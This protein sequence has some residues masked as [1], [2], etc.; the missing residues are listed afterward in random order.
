MTVPCKDSTHSIR[1]FT[2][3]PVHP[4]RSQRHIMSIPDSTPSLKIAVIAST[5]PRHEADYAVP[6]LRESIRHLVRRGHEVTVLAPSYEGLSDHAIDGVAVK[7]FRYSPRRWER[8]THEQGAPNR[9]R[10]PWYQLLGAPYVILGCLAA[11]RLAAKESFDIVHVHWPFPHAPLGAAATS[12][13]GAPLVMT[14]HGAEFALARRKPWVRECLKRGLRRADILIANS[15]DTAVQIKELSG[16]DAEVLAFGSTVEPKSEFHIPNEVPRILFTGRLIQ[17]KGV[18][19]LLR[20]APRVLERMRAKFII[21]GDGDQRAA[22]ERLR[23]ELS[24]Q[25]HVEFLGF[26]SKER[27]NQEYAQCDLWVNPSII[28]DRGD[29]EGLGVGAIEAYAHGKPVVCSAVG[30]IPDAVLHEITGLLVPQ[31][32]PDRLA[33]AILAILRNPQHANRMAAAGMEFARERF[34]WHR[35]SDRLEQIYFDAVARDHSPQRS[36]V[37]S[38]E[39]PCVAS[40]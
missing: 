8:L 33:A 40:T 6:W 9:I 22:L 34:C 4:S 10:N 13:C 26:V 27:L 38:A 21:T 2:P 20:A 32:D 24:L 7:R 17:R 28:D 23:D 16:R 36:A 5:Y 12:I 39:L 29:T 14:C 25:D 3:H 15:S 1:A 11:R 30:G 31:K 35:I 37:R 18:E 19:Y